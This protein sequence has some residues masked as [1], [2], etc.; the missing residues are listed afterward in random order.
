M[1]YPIQRL[2]FTILFAI[3]LDDLERLLKRPTE[4]TYICCGLLSEGWQVYPYNC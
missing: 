1:T 2:A 3:S 4:E